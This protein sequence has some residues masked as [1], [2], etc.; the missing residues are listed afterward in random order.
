DLQWN[1]IRGRLWLGFSVLVLLLLVAGAM[2]SRSFSGMSRTITQSLSEVQAEAGLA[3]QLSA[4]VAKTIE[5][6][7]RYLESRDAAALTSFRKYGWAAHDVQR[8]MNDL[9]GQSMIEVA[10]IASIDSKLSAM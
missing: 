4:D 7:S 1:T 5:A 2:T 9:P 8:R 6:G 10:T 3:S